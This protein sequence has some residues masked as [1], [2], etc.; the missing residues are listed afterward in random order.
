VT[1]DQTERDF[2]TIAAPLMAGAAEKLKPFCG[3]IKR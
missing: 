2:M 1:P 3:T